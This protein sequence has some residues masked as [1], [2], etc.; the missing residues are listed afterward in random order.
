[1]PKVEAALVCLKQG[2]GSPEAIKAR[3]EIDHLLAGDNA[4]GYIYEDDR[5]SAELI[6]FPGVNRP[7]PVTYGPFNQEGSLDGVLISVSGAD[8]TVHLQLQNR[9]IKYT[10]IITN[11]ETAR[12]LAKHMYEPVR[13]FGTGRWMRDVDGNWTLRTFRVDRFEP[14]RTDSLKDAVHQMRKI[15]GSGWKGMDDPVETLRALRDRSDGLH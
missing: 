5:E 2:D 1:M 8:Q 14:L 11:R 10:G 4:T 7:R 6:E 12:R 15:E 13:I 3:D 9:G